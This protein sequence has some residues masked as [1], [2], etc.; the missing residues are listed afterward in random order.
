MYF[1]N[2]EDQ[3]VIQGVGYFDRNDSY[4]IGVK[5]DTEGKVIFMIDGLENFDKNEKIFI[6]DS[7]NDSYNDIRKKQY[8][9]L[10]PSG[11]NN[12]RFSLCFKQ[13]TK[14]EKEESKDEKDKKNKKSDDIKVT[15]LQGKN[16][17]EINN[18]SAETNLQKV[19]LYNMNG[20][21]VATWMIEDQSQPNIQLP[22]K[23][24][25]SGI[26]IARIQTTNGDISKK[27]IIP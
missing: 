19:T 25:S 10:I 5:A 20:Q 15:N 11:E 4:P 17:I 2:G 12:D 21:S 6:Y 26:Y 7:E 8:E 22:I 14:K 16:T 23:N 13:K 24:L 9:V 27:I 3:L 18:K 1:L